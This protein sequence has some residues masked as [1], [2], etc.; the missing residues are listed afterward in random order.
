VL[1]LRD[2]AGAHK[3]SVGVAI[4]GHPGTLGGL[5]QGKL[6]SWIEPEDDLVSFLV[7]T[8][9]EL[10]PLTHAQETALRHTRIDA[11]LS[12]AA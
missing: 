5:S 11:V 4:G 7:A 6:G 3:S 10:A 2:S 1:F 12:L 9:S 8:M